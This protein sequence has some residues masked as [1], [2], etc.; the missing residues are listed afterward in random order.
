MTSGSCRHVVVFRSLD[1]K[2]HQLVPLVVAKNDF[3]V[4]HCSNHS[5]EILNYGVDPAARVDPG[6]CV[7]LT[8]KNQDTKH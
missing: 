7:F 4:V 6:E 1:E 8:R 3:S 5:Q 2:A